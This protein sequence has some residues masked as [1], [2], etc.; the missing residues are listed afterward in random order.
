MSTALKRRTV[1]EYL[2]LERAS[3]TKHEFY[4]GEI[5]ARAGASEPHNLIVGNIVTALNR[6]LSTRPCRVYPSDMRVLCPSGL[7]TYP[8]VSVVCGEPQLEGDE[9]D[10]LLNPL[11]IVEVLTGSTEKYDRTKKFEHYGEIP[12]L[13][14]YVLV[15]QDRMFVEHFARRP[16]S[17]QWVRTVFKDP[18]G[19]VR[20]PALNCE[21]PL[22][23]LYAKVQ[24]P[25]AEPALHENGPPGP[26]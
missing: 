17:D 3:E 4:D 14:E 9:Q 15:S 11:V 25:V 2:A 7:R 19:A 24:L 26:R 22:A 20:F 12:S 23:E 1:A 16:G 10:T 21:V 18:A 8:D 13:Q 5:F 6:A